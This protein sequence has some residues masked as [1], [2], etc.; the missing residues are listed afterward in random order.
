MKSFVAFF[1]ATLMWGV[2][3]VQFPAD[4]V[5]VPVEQVSTAVQVASVGNTQRVMPDVARDAWWGVSLYE[6]A[7]PVDCRPRITSRVGMREAP[8]RGAS[9]NH[10]GTDLVCYRK[11]S[12][13]GVPVRAMA[14]GVVVEVREVSWGMGT[15]VVVRHETSRETF[16]AVYG[17]GVEGSVR[18]KVGDEVRITDELFGMGNSGVSAGTHLHLE[19]YE[20]EGGEPLGLE[21]FIAERDGLWFP[22]YEETDLPVADWLLPNPVWSA[23]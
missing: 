15:S 18:V 2:G 21:E 9:T 7:L 16:L 23:G 20:V 11:G 8:T 22:D 10:R 4:E 6:Y 12:D 3:G 17:H 19:L 5:G 13:W 1:A 14:D